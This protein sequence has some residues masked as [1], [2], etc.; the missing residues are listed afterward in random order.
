MLGVI[1]VWWKLLGVGDRVQW[2]FMKNKGLDVPVPTTPGE[3]VT[4]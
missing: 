2:K 1:N 4:E 3:K